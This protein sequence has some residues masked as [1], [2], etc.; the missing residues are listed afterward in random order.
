MQASHAN[1]QKPLD[2]GLVG[3]VIEP[4][5][6]MFHT[7]H[8][9]LSHLTLHKA[10]LLKTALFIASTGV[11]CANTYWTTYCSL[12]IHNKSCPGVNLAL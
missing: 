8:L 6:E 10:L 11:I 12:F 1:A 9:Y 4:N 3:S 2:N 7:H 5:M